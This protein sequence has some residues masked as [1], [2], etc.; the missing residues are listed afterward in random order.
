[1]IR[2]LGQVKLSVVA[3]PTAVP[4]LRRFF[5]LAPKTRQPMRSSS[6]FRLISTERARG[7]PSTPTTKSE[8]AQPSGDESSQQMRS[9][10]KSIRL[11]LS[12]FRWRK[13]KNTDSLLTEAQRN[14]PTTPAPEPRTYIDAAQLAERNFGPSPP[15]VRTATDGQ[16]LLCIIITEIRLPANTQ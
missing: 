11:S 1:M 13:W 8:T 4:A 16:K 2:A 14:T 5:Y 15:F 10:A 12:L 7:L 6:N 9:A 3:A